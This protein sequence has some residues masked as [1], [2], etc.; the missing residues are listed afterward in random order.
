MFRRFIAGVLT[1]GAT[2]VL[3][4]MASDHPATHIPGADT[5]AA[6]EKG[7]PLLE[8]AQYKVHADA[9]RQGRPRCTCA[10]PTSSTSSRAPRRL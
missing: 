5:R 4:A 1:L 3:P 10:T 6:F 7:R 8:N 9:R 2:I